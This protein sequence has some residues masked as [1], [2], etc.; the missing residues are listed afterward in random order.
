MVSADSCFNILEKLEKQ[1]KGLKR[2]MSPHKTQLSS[3]F[4][5]GGVGGFTLAKNVPE[6]KVKLLV[7][8]FVFCCPSSFNSCFLLVVM[9]NTFMQAKG[10]VIPET[11]VFAGV[12][13]NVVL[14]L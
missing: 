2:A 7:A 3:S 12:T 11:N 1:A 8:L 9:L 5:F 4:L 14:A 10:A 6:E 13:E